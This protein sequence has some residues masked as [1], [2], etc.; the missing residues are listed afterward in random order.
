MAD[1]PKLLVFD[2][3]EDLL[4]I[5]RF[6]FEDEGWEVHTFTNCDHV[7]AH[8]RANMPQLILMDNWIPSTGGIEATKA[9]KADAQLRSI[10]VIYISANNDIKVLSEKAGADSFVAKPFDF[11]HLLAVAQ[12]LLA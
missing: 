8:A 9:L 4:L 6:L 7:I 2:D 5:F 11:D 1:K 10:P 3:D 12:H